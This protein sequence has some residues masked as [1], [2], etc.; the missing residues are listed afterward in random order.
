MRFAR[1]LAKTNDFQRDGTIKTFLAGSKY[2]PLS[3]A[4]NLLEQ[5]IIAEVHQHRHW[6]AGVIRL[7]RRYGGQVDPGYRFIL[8]WV[9]SRLQK[10]GA[11]RV[12]RG[13]G[14]NGCSAFAT[15]CGG[16]DSHRAAIPLT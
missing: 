5:F 6:R 8:G 12:L 9:E 13:I 2:H 7:R 11:A 14:R 10:A 3:A 15:K 1:P 16:C 4:S